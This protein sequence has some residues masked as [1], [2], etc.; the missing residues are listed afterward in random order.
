MK[1]NYEKEIKIEIDGRPHHDPCISHCLLYAFGICEEKHANT[2]QNCDEFWI[3]FE[4]LQD[5]I[6]KSSNGVLDDAQE[7]LCYY[8]SHQTRKVYLNS[9]FS[10][11]LRELEYEGAIL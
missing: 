1:L 4:N 11:L 7:K 2:C 3:L 9:Q 10:F 8:L 5:A 6:G